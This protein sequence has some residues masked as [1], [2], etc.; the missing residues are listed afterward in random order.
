MGVGG[1]METV[2]NLYDHLTEVDFLPDNL[3]FLESIR[4]KMDNGNKLLDNLL[5]MQEKGISFTVVKGFRLNEEEFCKFRRCIINIKDG[6]SIDEINSIISD[7][8]IKYIEGTL[9]ELSIL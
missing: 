8:S 9:Y 2:I 3:N 1:K 4:Y 6:I 5:R 7:I